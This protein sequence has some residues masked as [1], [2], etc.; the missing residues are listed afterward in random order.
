MVLDKKERKKYLSADENRIIDFLEE[1][2]GCVMQNEISSS[3]GMSKAKVS[4][5]LVGLEEKEIAFKKSVDG[6]TN[7][8]VLDGYVVP[9]D[10][11]AMGSGVVKK[12]DQVD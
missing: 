9:D 4:R 2:G 8:V 3:L 6:R 7:E 1:K 11:K 10:S 5:L 12:K